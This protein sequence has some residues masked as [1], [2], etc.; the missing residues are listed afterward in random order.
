MM[1]CMLV[2]KLF[3]NVNNLFPSYQF[4]QLLRDKKHVFVARV[5]IK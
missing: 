5:K 4:E 2:S 3:Q 1:Q